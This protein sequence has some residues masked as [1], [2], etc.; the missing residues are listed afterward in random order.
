[1]ARRRR[2]FNIFTLS[3]LD[4]M[5]CGFGA[6]LLFFFIINHSAEV[7]SDELN[8]EL[9]AEVSR[10]E[11]RVLEGERSLAR[12]RN[13][14]RDTEQQQIVTQGRSRQII[15]N[16]EQ[17]RIEL[18]ALAKQTLARQQ[19]IEALTA[20]LKSAEE[21]VKRLEGSVAA[22]DEQ[23]DAIR[24]FVGE[25]DRQYVTGL[26]VGG[27]RILILVDASASML[28]DTIVNIIRR[29]NMPDAQKL[30]APKWLW[31]IST[32]DWITAQIP[33]GSQFQV[34]TFNVDATPLL[35][36]TD[37]VWQHAEDGRRLTQA[38]ENLR[39]VVPD[40][41]TSLYRALGVIEALTP[42][43]DNIYL[44]T[45]GLPTQGESKATEGL[46]SGEARVELFRSALE[47]LPLGIPVNVILFPIE[48]DP[49]AASAYWQL[50][51]VTRGSF[52]SPSRD[53]P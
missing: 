41:G 35:K 36:G 30:S 24:S 22:D 33:I 49:M 46:I 52:L 31:A 8:R 45:D 43:P 14:L 17:T 44:L 29:R 5:A 28:D 6:V 53:W 42:R 23:G 7:R 18:A 48:G 1:M 51:Q 13:T 26:K 32:V 20:D 15:Q 47:N 21:Q 2:Q 50:A 27:E 34:Y 3:F 39:Q 10:L 37:G 40:G 11:Q 12:L 19:H 38:V 9:L 25:G 4:C 16:I